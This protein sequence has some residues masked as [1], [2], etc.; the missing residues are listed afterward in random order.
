MAERLGGRIELAAGRLRGRDAGF[1]GLAHEHG[2]D[3]VRRAPRDVGVAHQRTGQVGHL[4]PVG[5]GEFEHAVVVHL[6]VAQERPQCLQPHGKVA[7]QFPEDGLAAA[8][9]HDREARGPAL[10]HHDRGHGAHRARRDRLHVFE[11]V[12][13]FLLRHDAAGAA[14]AVGQFDHRE[15][16]GRPQEQVLGHPRQPLR[17][18][19]EHA[20]VLHQDVLAQDRIHGVR[21][22]LVEAQQLADAMAVDRE[23]AAGEDRRAR[24]RAVE[25]QV[26][27]HQPRRVAR[28]HRLEHREPVREGGRLR[29]LAVG[30]AGHHGVAM[31][32]GEFDQRLPHL[33]QR[34]HQA[35]HVMAHSEAP[36]DLGQVA[37]AAADVQVAADVV[38]ERA[39]QV[40]LARVHAAVDAVAGLG[41][42]FFFH[43]QQAAEQCGADVARDDAGLGQH[44]G[45]RLVEGM[46]RMHRFAQQTRTVEVEVRERLLGQAGA[47]G[48][49]AAVAV[50][51]L[52]HGVGPRAGLRAGAAGC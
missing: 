51:G 47:G 19:R 34:G 21:Q 3:L 20:H 46:D 16:G 52:L 40:V 28:E 39:D 48:A 14:V 49:E 8:P 11:A 31:A 38:A 22:R 9:L 42:A 13:I 37:R 45:M 18:R 1:L 7:P 27:G 24:R 6:E 23:V 36:R 32:P 30:V 12:G 29:M 4:R 10:G 2:D 33:A 50:V 35:V 43:R 41:D 25:P 15:L 17:Q 26:E 5:A 44:H